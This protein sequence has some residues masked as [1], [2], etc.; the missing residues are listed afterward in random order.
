[1][2]CQHIVTDTYGARTVCA[3]PIAE[4]HKRAAYENEL[5]SLVIVYSYYCGFHSPIHS[6]EAAVVEPVGEPVTA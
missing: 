1:M 6:D 4:V 2:H 3:E 5:K